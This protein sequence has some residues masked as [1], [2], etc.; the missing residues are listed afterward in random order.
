MWQE[1]FNTGKVPSS[2]K[3]QLVTPVHKTGS[4]S[5]PPNYRLIS[6]TPHEFKVFERVLRKK[7]VQFLESNNLLTCKQ[8]GFSKGRSCL[9]QLLKQYDDILLSLL[10]QS[11]TDVIYL[12]FD[13]VDHEILIQK[14]KNIGIEGKLLE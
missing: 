3:F 12:N 10:N 5:L 2:Y 11:E 7:M 6:L 13:K 1:S 14:L 9:S 8:H 4:Q